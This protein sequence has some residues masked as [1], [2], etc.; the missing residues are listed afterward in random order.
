MDSSAAPVIVRNLQ[1]IHGAGGAEQQGQGD[2][3]VVGRTG[4]RDDRVAQQRARDLALE[5]E[6]QGEQHGE[7]GDAE[8]ESG[9]AQH[10]PAGNAQQVVQREAGEGT[11][12]GRAAGA[13]DREARR[14][15]R[16]EAQELGGLATVAERGHVDRDRAL[17]HQVADVGDGR[18]R[19][20]TGEILD[21]LVL[22]EGDAAE[23]ARQEIRFDQALFAFDSGAGARRPDQYVVSGAGAVLDEAGGTG[24][25]GGDG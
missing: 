5:S 19:L 8:G 15:L 25:A 3:D 4:L 7:R 6:R 23:D 17:H 21:P 9:R 16:C 2:A 18:G 1:D 12:G 11:G 24:L 14:Q 13:G 10:R 20:D 22:T